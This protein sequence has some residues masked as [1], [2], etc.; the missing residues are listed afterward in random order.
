M[1]GLVLWDP[2]LARSAGFALSV[3]ATAALII[4]APRW[5]DALRRRGVPAGIAEAIAVPAAAHVACAPLIAAIG[6]HVSL[7]AI[8]ANMLVEPVVAPITIVGVVAA[9]VSPLMGGLATIGV[10]CAGWPARWLLAV[11]HYGAS[12]PAAQLGWASG[13][14]GGV[15]LAALL[16]ALAAGF[17]SRVV[18]I[19]LVALIVGITCVVVPVRLF[20][21]SWPPAHWRMVACDIGQ[22]DGLMLRTG[23]HSAIVVDTGPAPDAMDRCLQTFRVTQIPLLVLTH[24]DAD[25]VGG[26]SGAIRGRTV[27]AIAVSRL[28]QP[29][30]GAR[31]VH[32]IARVAHVRT[33]T[34]PVGWTYK[35]GGVSVELLSPEEPIVATDSDSNNNALVF[36]AVLRGHPSISVL[37]AA[38]M[39]REAEERLVAAGSPLHADVLKVPHHGSA[40]ADPDF[41]AKVAPSVAVISVGAHN[42]YGHP[43]AAALRYLH[44]THASIYRTDQD[45]DVV[46]SC[47]PH[48]W[49]V[50]TNH[51]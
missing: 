9:L 22:G 19:V 50:T 36:R 10:W 30:A 32:R 23:V 13:V 26:T 33:F 17:R 37:L 51:D 43:S 39:E 14:W 6:G 38:D 24:F 2:D 3:L 16:V 4:V 21:P 25:H 8:P 41:F 49:G 42:G 40:N 45:G 28:A 11:A 5:C 47:S 34:P 29:A 7:V 20:S 12:M 46:L 48:G 1:F 18:R 44:R 35:T 31:V 15:L 27:G